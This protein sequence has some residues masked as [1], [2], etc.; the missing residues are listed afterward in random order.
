M[1]VTVLI[2][3]HNGGAFLAEAVD[4]VLA[5]TYRD[6]ELLIVDDASTDGAIARL[7]AD[8]RI[9]V[10]RN[11]RNLG[12][13][14]SLNLGLA[15]ARGSYIARLDADDA[16]RPTRLERQVAILDAE[17]AVGLVGTW[18]EVVDET[19]RRW[20][21]L[22]GE[23]GDYADFVIAVLAN[24]FPFGHPALMY[25]REEVRAL[26]G[27]DAKLAPSEDKDLYRRLALAR[28]EARVVAEPLTRYRRHAAQL[29]QVQIA[30]QLRNDRVGLERFLATLVPDAQV[31]ALRA[32]LE[33]EPSYW[34]GPPLEVG[35]LEA[36]VAG[37][38]TR[39]RLEA[40]ELRRV[41]EAVAGQCTRALRVGWTAP[42]TAHAA[43]A[44]APSAFVAAHGDLSERALVAV[45]PLVRVSRPLAAA[46]AR[47][48]AAVRRGLRSERLA[49]VRVAARRSRTLR[50]L[51]AKLLGFR[52][53]DE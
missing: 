39:L 35:D 45:Q 12:Q 34:A 3:V 2:A 1:R 36:L 6:F 43:H 28:R 9:R 48:R 44:A 7:R 46:G 20:G 52:L 16:M 23:L 42:G 49:S 19:G 33:G 41:R 40:D 25:R 11:E 37:A 32:L 4:S 30:R 15:E 18:M 53:L 21:E 47:H 51:Y 22:R 14:P 31:G 8:S 38:A 29:S 13:V 10:V 26:G 50:R 24:H 17:P 27:Y 5:Q